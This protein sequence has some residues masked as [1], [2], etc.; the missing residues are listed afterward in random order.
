MEKFVMKCLV[1]GCGSNITL[2][3]LG[4]ISKNKP[5]LLQEKKE[6]TTVAPAPVP[7]DLPE[8]EACTSLEKFQPKSRDN[9]LHGREC[10]LKELIK[11]EKDYV[12]DLSYIIDGYIRIINDPNSP[13]KR[14]E[15]FPET[16]QR[17]LF[18]NIESIYKFHKE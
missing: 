16:K 8:P 10:A 12:R 3:A 1:S 15:S 18:G 13:I 9:A 4:E 14:P 5:Y 17:L 6:S 11:T 7:A 2:L